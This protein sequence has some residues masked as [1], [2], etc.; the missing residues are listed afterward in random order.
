MPIIECLVNK[1][2]EDS[3]YNC[4]R[5]KVNSKFPIKITAFMKS[6]TGEKKLQKT[7]SAGKKLLTC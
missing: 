4:L 1:I 5:I 2:P 6:D 3:I 7:G